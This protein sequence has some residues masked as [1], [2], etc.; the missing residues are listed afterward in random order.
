MPVLV[1][2]ITELDPKSRNGEFSLKTFCPLIWDRKPQNNTIY[3]MIIIVNFKKL[4]YLVHTI[5]F[6][7][8]VDMGGE[9]D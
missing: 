5:Y 2:G 9:G 1:R 3:G 6:E 4:K 8:V 7:G